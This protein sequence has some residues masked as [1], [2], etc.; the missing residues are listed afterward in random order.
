MKSDLGGGGLSNSIDI[1]QVICNIHN[2]IQSSVFCVF[3]IIFDNFFSF[4]DDFQIRRIVHWWQ[5]GNVD[6]LCEYLD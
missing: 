2:L 4:I 6:V 5:S 1:W 3:F